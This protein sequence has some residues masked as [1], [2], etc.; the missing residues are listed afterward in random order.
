MT[1][2]DLARIAAA[3]GIELPQAYRD[4]M[5]SRGASLR[6]SGRF[7]DDLSS[8][9]M[10]PAE[11]IDC[12]LLERP[13]ESGTG[14]VFPDWWQQFFL[15]GTNGAGD[16]YCLR[17]DDSP[18][19]WMI[20]SDC[21]TQPRHVAGTL[22]EF[23]DAKLADWQLEFGEWEEV[24]EWADSDNAAPPTD[25]R[26]QAL[27][28]TSGP[29]EPWVLHWVHPTIDSET[30]SRRLGEFGA[31][32]GDG[33]IA[34]SQLLAF[35]DWLDEQGD[36]AWG[37]YIRVRCALDRAAPGADY[38]SLFEE[39]LEAGAAMRPS[40]ANFG[41]FSFIGCFF[42]ADDWWD[43][44]AHDYARGL[45]SLAKLS[46]TKWAVDRLNAALHDLVCTTPFRGLD[47][48]WHCQ[49]D[50]ADILNSPGA[51]RLQRISF[52][53]RPVRQAPVGPWRA[54]WRRATR[55]AAPADELRPAI[56]AL[57]GASCAGGLERLDIHDGIHSD[58]DA[59]A[60]ADARFDRLRHFE[61]LAATPICC[62]EK[63]TIRL[64]SAPW[65]RGLERTHLGFDEKCCEAG[66]VRL[67]GMPRLHTLGL[68]FPPDRQLVALDRAG[69]FPALRRLFMHGANLTGECGE[70]LMRMGAPEL[71]ELWLRNSKTGTA[72]VQGLAASRLFDRLCALTFDGTEID[73][74]GLEALAASRVS[75]QLRILRIHGGG[76]LTGE[77]RALSDTPLTRRGAFPELTTLDL[78]YPFLEQACKDTSRFLSRLA[79][80]KLRHLTLK[81]CD[82]DD[83][84]ADILGRHAG[85]GKPTRLALDGAILSRAGVERLLR[86]PLLQSLVELKI[87]PPWGGGVKSAF[88][89]E[90]LEVLLDPSVLPDLVG[91]WLTTEGVPEAVIDQLQKLRPGLHI[92]QPLK[93]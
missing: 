46:E 21:G 22:E 90:S 7:D 48:E 15:V 19:V 56:K 64:L 23:V 2:S 47:L 43:D 72:D 71:L 81:G 41:P 44:G 59:L 6:E 38:A 89:G 26:V 86:S 52:A 77:F 4:L 3:L 24:G 50:L 33:E 45:P 78:S 27:T 60:L 79:I 18:G 66:M 35:A 34:T 82:F 65:F 8:F 36:P 1:E 53:N 61:I 73:E 14:Y 87:K 11:V 9:A 51:R 13:R 5:R 83:E 31:G 40:H 55:T 54:W 92:L 12:N 16:Y 84:C 30:I 74:A 85:M 68:W 10:D 25:M 42:A 63:A 58:A 39:Y 49:D 62:S 67:A 91:G 76:D 88:P 70:A 69:E 32:T 29:M 57:V 20:G 37:R 75:Q 80:P 17:L 93:T 28:T